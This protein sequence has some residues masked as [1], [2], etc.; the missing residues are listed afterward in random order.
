MGDKDLENIISSIG[1]EELAVAQKQA[2]IDRLKQLIVKQRIEMTEQQ[3]II[4]DLNDR[5]H[6]MYNG[7]RNAR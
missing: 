7:G 4:K 2:Q 1:Q 3:K 5:M 6:H